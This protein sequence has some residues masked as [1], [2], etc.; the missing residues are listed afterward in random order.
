MDIGWNATLRLPL[1]FVRSLHDIPNCVGHGLVTLFGEMNRVEGRG[2]L[3]EDTEQDSLGNQ[4][5][6]KLP[7]QATLNAAVGV[8]RGRQ[9]QLEHDNNSARAADR[10]KQ[11]CKSRFKLCGAGVPQDVV[12]TDLQQNEPLVRGNGGRLAQ[13]GSNIGTR[14]R[15]VVD[16]NAVAVREDSGPGICLLL[17][18]PGCYRITDD[19]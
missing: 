13:R 7:G 2:L 15:M 10:R 4:D 16:H 5:G 11:T 19:S 9:R 8:K 6:I 14:H 1:A 18:Q 17:T 3:L 12:P